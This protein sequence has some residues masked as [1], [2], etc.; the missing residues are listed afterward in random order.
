VWVAVAGPVVVA[1][2]GGAAILRAMHLAN[3][4]L[5]QGGRRRFREAAQLMVHLGLAITFVAVALSEAFSR[6]EQVTM[7]RG[8]SAQLL[9][10]TLHME[11]SEVKEEAGYETLVASVRVEKPGGE[12]YV[13][14]PEVRAYHGREDLSAEVALKTGLREDVLLQITRSTAEGRLSFLLYRKPAVLW[15]WVGG[16]LMVLGGCIVTALSARW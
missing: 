3:L 2:A 5:R 10:L 14:T 4:L 9:G 11:R 8:T 6:T 15:L 7:E 16:A 12:P 1:V 13:L